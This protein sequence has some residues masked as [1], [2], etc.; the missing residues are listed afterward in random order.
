M[1]WKS[2]LGDDFKTPYS[3]VEIHD[4]IDFGIN[5]IIESQDPSQL[6]LTAQFPARNEDV[7]MNLQNTHCIIFRIHWSDN[8]IEFIYCR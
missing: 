3:N 6:P 2:E 8:K 4:L 7:F 5:L 1:T